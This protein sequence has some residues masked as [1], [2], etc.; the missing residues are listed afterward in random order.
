MTEETY[1]SIR[2]SSDLLTQDTR[3]SWLL[4]DQAERNLRFEYDRISKDTDLTDEARARKAQAVYESRREDIKRKKQAAREA[5]KKQA[6]TAQ[7]YSIPRPSGEALSSTDASEL[8]LD[9]LE[10]QRIVRT[11][12]RR[13]DHPLGGSRGTTAYLREEFQRGMETGGVEG[14][15]VVRGCLRAA[16]EL[17]VSHEELLNPLRNDRQR[18]LLDNARRLEYFSELISTS[19]PEPPKSLTASRARGNEQFAR[20]P[21]PLFVGGHDSTPP[22]APTP[23]HGGRRRSKKSKR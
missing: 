22:Q 12:E 16:R 13:G 1:A 20:R 21:Q 3:Q 5:L 15:S 7:E 17:G 23:S 4:A 6:K 8:L 10:A 2:D 18:K 11:I 19:V 14:G 9:A